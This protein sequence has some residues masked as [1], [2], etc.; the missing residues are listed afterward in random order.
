MTDRLNK[1]LKALRIHRDTHHLFD[2]TLELIAAIEAEPTAEPN[3]LIGTWEGTSRTDDGGAFIT[4]D[5]AEPEVAVS[6]LGNPDPA[7]KHGNRMFCAECSFS[8][9]PEPTAEPELPG[10][11]A[12]EMLDL[13]YEN[14]ELRAAAAEPEPR[15]DGFKFKRDDRVRAFAGD[16]NGVHGTVMCHSTFTHVKWDDDGSTGMEFDNRLEPIPTPLPDDHIDRHW[17]VGAWLAH[18][19][20]GETFIAITKQEA[21]RFNGCG[22]R[23]YRTDKV[24][25]GWSFHRDSPIQERREL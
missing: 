21:V 22:G 1:A 18:E 16:K 2:E 5:T 17:I 6:G 13:R 19:E 15:P 24:K 9:D 7:C 12:Q 11:I 3:P 25:T 20:T 10:D 14:L 4:Y 23:A 8:D